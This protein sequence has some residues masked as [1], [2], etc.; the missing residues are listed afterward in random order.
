VAEVDLPVE[1]DEDDEQLP[2]R[3]AVLRVE[4]MDGLRVDR[5]RL[6]IRVEETD[7]EERP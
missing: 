2:R 5:V 1:L 6:A 7:G 4:H 3:V